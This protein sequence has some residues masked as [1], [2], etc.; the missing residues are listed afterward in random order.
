MQESPEENR[1]FAE[2]EKED[3][4]DWEGFRRDMFGSDFDMS[5]VQFKSVGN[6]MKRKKID[7][8]D[9]REETMKYLQEKSFRGLY[10]RLQFWINQ[11]CKSLK[12]NESSE[13]TIK[14]M[15][16]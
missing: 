2:S 10:L 3:E 6:G 12:Q 9:N 1:H 11:I 4:E 15:S 13:T 7:S 16:L 14:H 5:E 8:G